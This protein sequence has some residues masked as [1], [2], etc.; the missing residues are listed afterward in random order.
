[1]AEPSFASITDLSA[2]MGDVGDVEAALAALEDASSLI[3]LVSGR[4]WIDEEDD[5]DEPLTLSADTPGA[6]KGICC[7][8]AR[9][10]L[11]NPEALN[12]ESVVNYRAEYSNASTDVYL[13][14][15]EIKRIRQAAGLGGVTVIST[16]R[17]EIE[18]PL[19]RYRDPYLVWDEEWA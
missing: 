1:M 8:A 16:T 15:S 3:H 14:K 11:E 17:E 4:A 13:T 10:V 9:R 19:V 7:A 5:P 2:R 12:A 18:T 6:M